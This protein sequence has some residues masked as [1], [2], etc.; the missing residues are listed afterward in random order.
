MSTTW[1]SIEERERRVRG[2]RTTSIMARVAEQVPAGKS[3]EEAF[4]QRPFV[5][6]EDLRNIARE[7]DDGPVI[8]LYLNFTPERL[9][10][11]DRPVFLSVFSSL[12][13]EALETRKAYVESLPH[14][15][16]LRVPEDLREVQE[17]LETFEPAGARAVVI[18][19][20]GE[21]LNR[22]MPLPV[23]V[24][25][26]L[27]IDPDSY[28][29]PLEA[30]MEEQHRVLVLD[31]SKA[32]TTVSI[33]ELGYELKIDTIVEDLP[34]ESHEPFREGKAERHRE[35]HVIWHFKASAQLADRVFREAGTDLIILVGE[36]IVVKE[37]EEYLPKALRERVVGRLH[38]APETAP[39]RRRAALEDLLNE[40]RKR[41][42]EA[43]LGELGFYQGH[44]RL[45]A[46]L[47]MVLSAADL[48]LMRQ[49]F[50]SEDLSGTGFIC[51]DH[52]F[53]ALKPGTCPF[54]NRPLEEAE[55]L[56][57]ELIE[58]A[59]LHGVDVMVVTQRKD[60]LAP[61]GGIAAVLVTAT[62]LDEL[63]T[64]SVTS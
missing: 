12:R 62:T 21:Q 18:F 36:E 6:R 28:I 44:Q 14:A 20:S 39:N 38:L 16:R 56:L 10:R 40:Q 49:L 53:L 51:H 41:E 2:S 54:D 5:S 13:H 33:Y 31:V 4:A 32:R 47:E 57:D 37:F 30:I 17:F 7:N 45:A 15:P 43:A 3:L 42:E 11:A 34:R 60:L 9:V 1:E 25:D 24:A 27:V 26:H 52:H 46:G 35:T 64:V 48:F 61:Y 19:K 23:R 29:E 59:R 8:S 58:M 63:R 55:Y 50:V 22:V